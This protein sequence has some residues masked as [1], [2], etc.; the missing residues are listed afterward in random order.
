MAAQVFL[1]LRTKPLM[2]SRNF[3][4]TASLYAIV[5]TFH[6]QI[7]WLSLISKYHEALLISLTY[8]L[9]GGFI[10]TIAQDGFRLQDRGLLTSSLAQPVFPFV[11][12]SMGSYRK[13]D[14]TLQSFDHAVWTLLLGSHH[15]P[16]FP[17][18]P[19]S[20][21]PARQQK[22]QENLEPYHIVRHNFPKEF[23]LFSLLKWGA[24]GRRWSDRSSLLPIWR[25]C[26]LLCN[27]F[28]SAFGALAYHLRTWYL[29]LFMSLP[30]HLK[31]DT[32]FW[33][34]IKLS[35]L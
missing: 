22:G 16:S 20:R 25:A 34:L 14:N 12:Q 32:E 4:H 11:R 19:G 10:E 35:S 21:A 33:S 30:W 5:I 17:R 13:A 15:D 28:L 27:K 24:G 18:Q 3:A 8:E 26:F 31:C 1:P 29:F 6:L 2:P 23:V 9:C 7:S